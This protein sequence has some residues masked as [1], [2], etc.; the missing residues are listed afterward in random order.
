MQLQQL[1]RQTGGSEIALCVVI[2]E[3]VHTPHVEP[4]LV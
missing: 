3:N 4:F 2:A 1:A